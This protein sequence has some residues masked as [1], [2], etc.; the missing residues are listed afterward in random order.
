MLSQPARINIGRL[1]I[2]PIMESFFAQNKDLQYGNTKTQFYSFQS[3]NSDLPLVTSG[4]L[5]GAALAFEN[6]NHSIVIKA[7]DDI[8]KHE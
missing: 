3:A 2:K 1:E 5:D 4:L 6:K 7:F 8:L